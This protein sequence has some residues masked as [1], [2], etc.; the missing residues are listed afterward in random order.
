MRA[1]E[2]DAFMRPDDAEGAGAGAGSGS[3]SGVGAEEADLD[4]SEDQSMGGADDESTLGPARSLA[5]RMLRAA[6]NALWR[7]DDDAAAASR[8]ARD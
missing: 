1:A 6:S 3:G 8:Q 5:G 7:R 4:M 2:V